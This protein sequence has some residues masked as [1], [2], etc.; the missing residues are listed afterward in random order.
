MKRIILKLLILSMTVSV[1]Y[2]QPMKNSSGKQPFSKYIP[3]T[4]GLYVSVHQLGEFNRVLHL[5][6]LQKMLAIVTGQHETDGEKND[7]QSALLAFIG[8]GHKVDRKRLTKCEVGI[9][10]SSLSD[11][12][13]VMWFV[14]L[15]QG[16]HAKLWFPESSPKK[17][18]I[19]SSSMLYRS[20]HGLIVLH[21]EDVVVLARPPIQ[22]LFLREIYHLMRDQKKSS[23][24]QHRAYQELLAY[25][26]PNSLGTIFIV[27]DKNQTTDDSTSLLWPMLESAL[28]GMYERDGQVDFTV[29]AVTRRALP[30]GRVTTVA[31][32]R[33]LDLPATTLFAMVTPLDLNLSLPPKDTAIASTFSRY[34]SFLMRYRGLRWI[35][36]GPLPKLGPHL[37]VAWGQ[38]LRLDKAAPQLAILLESKNVNRLRN[39]MTAIAGNLIEMLLRFPPAT[40]GMD[41][42]LQQNSHL[43]IPIYSVTI[44]ANTQDFPWSQWADSIEPCWAAW[45][46]W[47]IFALSRDHLERILDAQFGMVPTMATWDDARSIRRQSTN[48]SH[49]ALMQ[50]RLA[51][52]V[53]NEWMIKAGEPQ[54]NAPSHLFTNLLNPK[55][56]TSSM[57]GIGVHT[58]QEQGVVVV[59]RVY[60]DGLASGL[61]E[62]EDRIIGLDGELLDLESPNADVRRRWSYSQTKPGPTF[63]VIRSGAFMDIVV[64]KALSTASNDPLRINPGDVIRDAISLGKTIPFAS[65]VAFVS[66]ENHYSAKFTIRMDPREQP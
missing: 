25:K 60:P 38:D 5:S 9:V 47:F 20:A 19:T 7:I 48:R 21:H 65:F 6:P 11:L 43:G 61:L 46:G 26:P 63:R 37:I 62:P 13:R 53:L 49:I 8:D 39:E 51:A 54:S 22:G 40:G 4:A 45:R 2:G 16:V 36:T 35:E 30:A 23:L 12:S 28:F 32:E 44:Q 55:P 41:L 17:N 24:Q 57:L 59:A 10:A 1:A 31:M 66:D 18:Q 3:S 42:S 29:R 34:L 27:P 58:Q 52:D 15:P 56:K 64:P 50:P 33:F 14:R